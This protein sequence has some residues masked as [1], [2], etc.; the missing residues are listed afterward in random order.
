MS[1]GNAKT[2]PKLAQSIGFCTP[3]QVNALAEAIV[4]TQRDHGDRVERKHARL[5]YTI[6]DMGLEVFKTEVEKRSG[7]T[8]ADARDF[9]FDRIVDDYG[10]TR[11]ADGLWSYVH[12]IQSGRIAGAAKKALREMADLG[13]GDIRLTPSQN[14]ALCGLD[15]AARARV[16]AI[17]AAHGL[18]GHHGLTGLR[19]NSMACPALPTCGLALAE[20]ERQL[21]EFLK[22]LEAVLV[23]H[24]LEN[25]PISIRS[26]GCPNGCAR[27]YLA[28]IGLVGKAPGKYNLYLGADYLGAR[29]NT[30][31]AAAQTPEQIIE[32]LSGLL[33]RYAEEREAGERFGDFCHRIGAVTA[34][35]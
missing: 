20:S 12:F 28:E 31:V 10:W 16:E 27:P 15:D 13:V 1:H 32:H 26:T 25:D 18:T 22:A 2:Y 21:P 11:G 14:L 3:D 8:L 33:K 34:A 5:K 7:I 17:L 6:E 23:E 19:L 30:E 24:G 35:A 9:A 4:T 29:L